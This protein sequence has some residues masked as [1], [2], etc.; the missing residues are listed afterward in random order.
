L[1]FHGDFYDAAVADCGCHDNRM[2]K[3]WWNEQ[4][5]DWPIDDHYEDN[6]NATHADKLKGDLL[7]TVGE[8]DTNVDP[9]STMQVAH[10]LIKADKDF[11]LLVVPGANHG[12]G[13]RPYLRRKRVEFFQRVLGGSVE[14]VDGKSTALPPSGRLFVRRRE[15]SESQDDGIWR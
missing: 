15:S 2:D 14:V 9:S 1:L 10:A 8:V 6:S 11:E 5:M 3:I 7:L 12:V 13:E 4:W